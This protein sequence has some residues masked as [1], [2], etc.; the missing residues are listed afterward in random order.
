MDSIAIEGVFGDPE[1]LKSVISCSGVSC[2]ND[3][4]DFPMSMQMISTLNKMII[5]T[6]FNIK[7]VLK[8]D[9]L[10]DSTISDQSNQ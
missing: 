5:S 1:A 3:D 7:L 4:D 6:E 10:N 2:F 8:E 9:K